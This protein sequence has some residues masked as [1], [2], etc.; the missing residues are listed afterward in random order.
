MEEN[1]NSANQRDFPKILQIEFLRGITHA[2]PFVYLIFLMPFF[3]DEF[4]QIGLEQENLIIV[5]ISVVLIFPS[6]LFIYLKPQ[7][8]YWINLGSSI[9][10]GAFAM[11]VG[12]LFNAALMERILLK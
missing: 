3:V 2:I 11:F 8:Q 9:A 5:I 6:L 4:F 1:G 10:A 7:V 12:V